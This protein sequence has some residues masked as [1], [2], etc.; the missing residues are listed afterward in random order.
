MNNM[1]ELSNTVEL[2]F[3]ALFE[4]NLEKFDQVF[5]PSCSLF[6]STDGILTVVPIADYRA[7]IETRTSPESVGQLRDDELISVDF[8]SPSAAVAK[9]R[10]RIHDKVFIDHL[11]FAQSD[12]KFKIVAKVWHDMTPVK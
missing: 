4:C 3:K 2:Y 6:D 9:V 5:H 1:N 10:L 7:V 11:T 8:L 12:G